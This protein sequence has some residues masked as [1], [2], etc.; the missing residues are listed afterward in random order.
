MLYL[1]LHLLTLALSVL[2]WPAETGTQLH[3]LGGPCLNVDGLVDYGTRI[4]LYAVCSS[5]TDV[6]RRAK[7]LRPRLPRLV[8][9]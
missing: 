2:A 7:R 3:L 5:Q 6:Q 8:P 9:P 4:A 1:L